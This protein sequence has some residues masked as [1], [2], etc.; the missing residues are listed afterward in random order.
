[1]L[2]RLLAGAEEARPGSD[3]T[4][5]RGHFSPLLGNVASFAQEAVSSVTGLCMSSQIG[6]CT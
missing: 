1:M 6:Q 5:A 3:L 4:G 2:R